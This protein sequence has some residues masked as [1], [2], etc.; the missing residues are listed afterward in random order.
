MNGVSQPIMAIIKMVRRLAFG[1]LNI[2]RVFAILLNWFI[3]NKQD[4]I[5]QFS[6]GGLYD[7]A[8]HG[9]KYGYWIDTIDYFGYNYGEP[10]IKL[11]G[12]YYYGTKVGI[13]NTWYK[14]DEQNEKMKIIYIFK[15]SEVKD[16]MIKE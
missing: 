8:G 6:G 5:Y 3:K 4:F 10:L 1:I 13:W 2:G 11:N 16:V 14:Q 12:Q 15:L 9:L 7:E